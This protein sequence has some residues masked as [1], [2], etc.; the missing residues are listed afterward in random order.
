MKVL[1]TQ[2]A[3]YLSFSQLRLK[4]GGMSF[5]GVSLEGHAFPLGEGLVPEWGFVM[6]LEGFKGASPPVFFLVGV[7]I[8]N[9][10][11][12]KVEAGGGGSGTFFHS[13]RD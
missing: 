8:T 9:V 12:G 5:C 10:G 4:G 3:H 7:V 6:C 11:W 13:K 1:K 2:G